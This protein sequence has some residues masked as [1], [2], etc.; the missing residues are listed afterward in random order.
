ME[1]AQSL[2]GRAEAG[3]EQAEIAYQEALSKLQAAGVSSPEEALKLAAEAQEN[4]QA[5]IAEIE[6]RLKEATKRD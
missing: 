1:Q 3:A 2:K 6:S 5:E 4:V